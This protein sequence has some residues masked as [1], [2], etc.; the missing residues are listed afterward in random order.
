MKITAINPIKLRFG[1]NNGLADGLAPIAY[2][3][4]FLVEVVTDEGIKGI[5]EGFALGSLNSMQTVLEETIAPLVLG[6]DPY[7]IPHI[8]EKV[9][10]FTY[11]Y[12]R[13]GIVMAVLSALDIALWDIVG[14]AAQKPVYKLLGADKCRVAAYASGGYYADGKGPA[15]LAVEAVH[16][17]EMGFS[18]MKMKLGA[19][20]L[21]EDLVRVQAVRD[22]IG[23]EMKLAVDANNAYDFNT[24]V[25]MARMLEP[26][27]LAF[28]EEPLSGDSIDDSI[29]LG[30]T[31]D[32]PIAG[33]ETE[34]TRF[35][36]RDFITRRGVDIVQTDVIWAGG[37]T[38]GRNIANLAS[39]WKMNCIPHFSAGAVSLAANLHFAAAM[40]NV[41][42]IELTLDENPLRDNLSI[43]PIQREGGDLILSDRPGLGVELD[44]DT[45]EKYRVW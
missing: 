21:K 23:E 30:E 42:I 44:P 15:E 17:K 38:E 4:V 34:L 8:W 2:R 45:V 10:H 41:P 5:G 28:F 29:R 12:G 18:T 37:I 20:S 39:A 32:I 7:Y 9:Y 24:A 16:Y 22:G 3:D 33:Y 43:Y 11:R 13:R 6:E 35:A 1:P 19:L 40:T 27:N 25:K 36:L 14:K 26:L 31:T